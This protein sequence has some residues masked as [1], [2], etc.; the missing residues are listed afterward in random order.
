[1]FDALEQSIDVPPYVARTDL[2]LS[3]CSAFLNVYG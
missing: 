1:M 2:L 3:P